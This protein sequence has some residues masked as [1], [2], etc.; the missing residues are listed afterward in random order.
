MGPILLMQRL[1]KGRSIPK[2]KDTQM[3]RHPLE[4]PEDSLA[5][6]T[7]DGSRS[8]IYPASV[9]GRFQRYRQSLHLA[10]LGFFLA[11]PWIK[12]GG[13]QA[14]LL[15]IPDRHFSVFGLTFLAHDAPIFFFIPAIFALCLIFVT[16]MWGRLWCGWA[17]PQ[18]VFIETIFRRIER[19]IEGNHLA[20]RKLNQ[21]SLSLTK[22]W[23]KSLKWV[24]F[25]FVTLIVTHTFIAY[26]VGSSELLQIIQGP[27]TE[28]WP[29]FV[30]MAI[31]S[32]IFLF[33][34]GW[35]REQFCIIACPYGRFQSVML[36]QKTINIFYDEKRGEPRKGKNLPTEQQ[37][38]C[39]NCFRCVQVCPTG[40]DIRRGTPQ[41]ECIACTACIDACDEIMEKVNKPRGLIR[42]TSQASLEGKPKKIFRLIDFIYIGLILLTI[43]GFVLALSWRNPLQ[44]TLLRAKDIPYRSVTLDD[45]TP[46]LINHFSLHIVN[47]STEKATMRWQIAEPWSRQGVSVVS[48]LNELSLEPY[49]N[50]TIH[51]FIKF[52][53]SLLEKSNAKT[54]LI[55]FTRVLEQ[56]EDS[57]PIEAKLLGPSP[58]SN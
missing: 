31:L 50:Q 34:F 19:W 2:F 14:V 26:F 29:A 10:L 46:G 11:L 20:Q 16:A 43:S 22:L 44:L 55:D 9:R 47:Q 8:Y 48:Q 32:A 12:I 38:D 57:I 37:G 49:K 53:L 33:D 18:T 4:L 23:K 52:P 41:L 42:Y 35:F 6:L 24:L 54:I 30:A 36:D 28:N 45:G 3:N 58:G 56:K 13:H 27:P 51:L 17:C 5:S 15:N 25:L 39:I 7:A 21:E 1:L 40:V